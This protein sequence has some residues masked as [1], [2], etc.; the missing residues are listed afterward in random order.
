VT[1]SLYPTEAF[2]H[3]EVPATGVLMTNLGSPEA[4]TAEALKPYL[5]EFLS[6]PRVIE[7]PRWQW[8]P[9]L[10]LII[11]Q[12]R[13]KAS[14]ELYKRIWTDEGSPLLVITRRIA[15]GLAERL[16]RAVGSPLHVA[17]GMRY[18]EPSI[19]GALRELRDKGCRRVLVLP[20]YPQYSATTTATTFD[21]VAAELTGW[22]RVP[23]VRT[24][25]GWHD[26]SGYAGA[27]VAS[28]VESFELHGKP[29]KV[30]FSF[31][32]IPLR[33]FKEGDPYHCLCHKTARLTADA[34]GLPENGWDVSF[35]SLFG[36][37]EWLKPYTEEVIK[38]MPGAGV[39]SLHVICPGFSADC[40]ETLDEIDHE[41]RKVWVDSGGEDAAYRYVP[42]LN[43]RPDHLDFLTRLSLEN[44]GGWVT[45]PEQWSEAEARREAEASRC[46]AE[47]L[48]EEGVE[49]DAGYG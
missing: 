48:A 13:P 30:L 39:E 17:V 8:L 11:L 15:E 38:A 27:L 40:L 19:G 46:R 32:G 14:A 31:H 34:L 20:L 16:E 18:G 2:E 25:H 23:E 22:R 29:Q 49:A 42:A 35:Q 43:D 3:G 21:A 41:Y 26:R 47:A 1:R 10:N 9:I 28:L 4:P 6:D 37:E 24:I 7:L 33:Y 36:R 12:R 44:L 5:A 45:P